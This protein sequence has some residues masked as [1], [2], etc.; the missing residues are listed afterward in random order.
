M[1]LTKIYGAPGTGKTTKMLDLLQK[2]IKEGISVDRIAFLTHSVA[3]RDEASARIRKLLP[4]VQESSFKYFRT[5]HGVCFSLLS[6]GKQ[7][8][9]QPSDFLKFGDLVGIQFSENFTTDVDGDGL[10]MGYGT[11]PGNKMLAVRQF[12]AAQDVSIEQIQDQWPDKNPS[13]FIDVINQYAKYK[14]EIAKFDFVDMLTMYMEDPTP[15]DVDVI[16]IDEAQDLSVLQW[17][18]VNAFMA[19]AQRVYIAGDDDQAIYTFI[20]A[21][22]RGFLNYK[23]DQEII[24]PK[25]YRLKENIW[26]FAQNI[27]SQVSYRQKKDIEVNGSGGEIDFWNKPIEYLDFDHPG[28]TMVIARHHKQLAKV[29]KALQKHGI[30]YSWKGTSLVNTKR[31]QAIYAWHVLA[32]GKQITLKQASLII[33]MIAVD[34]KIVLAAKALARENKDQM[35]SKDQ[36]ADQYSI[37]F[38]RSWQTTLAKS[39]WDVRKNEAIDNILQQRGLMAIV[40]EPKIDLTTYHGCKGR[41]A[42]HVVLISDCYP[43]AYKSGRENPDDERRLAYV[44]VTRAIDKL[45]IVSP[46]TDMYMKAL[47]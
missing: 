23:A 27:I 3:A 19:N 32:S 44:G 22:P 10:P 45:T 47:T 4:L 7:H 35:V 15:L 40:E 17:K 5:I 37:N 29:A 41:E 46:E 18:V 13:T 8:V 1:I 6:I 20:G 26:Q 28:K 31:A 30:A 21:S 9:M 36:L 25:T 16:F 24:L 34:R 43:A 2:E 12:A 14:Q 11:S 38:D 42:N 39:D 33:S